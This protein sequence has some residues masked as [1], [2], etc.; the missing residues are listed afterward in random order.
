MTDD[1]FRDL[2]R[3]AIDDYYGEEVVDGSA[4]DRLLHGAALRAGPVRRPGGLQAPGRGPG[5]ARPPGGARQ[6]PVLPGHAAEPVRRPD[7]AARRGRPR[8]A[9]RVRRRA[10]SGRH[11]GLDAGRHREAVRPRPGRRRANWTASIGQVFDERQVYRI[12][13]YLGKE[14]VQNILVFRF[15]NA[16]FEPLWNRR[17]VDHV[18]ITVAETSASSTAAGYYEQAGALRDMIQN[19][20]LQ[21][22][23]LVAMEPPAAFDADAVRD[24]KVKVLR[25]VRPITCPVGDGTGRCAGSTCRAGS[26]SRR[27]RPTAPRSGSRRTRN[28]ETFA[29]LQA[30]RRQLAL[31]GRAVL[32]AHRQA[33]GRVASPRSPSTSS[34][35]RS[36]SSASPGGW[37]P[38]A[39]RPRPPRAAG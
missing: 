9:R 12:D 39:Q 27:R 8:P 36:R 23:S 29:A 22:L 2:M 24:E 20:L 6:P 18:Q 38:A 7:R 30:L 16:I 35:R 4:C 33:P 17:Y 19:H 25:A 28:T 34:G 15:A 31:A 3:T 10:Q 32:P 21:L 5:R 26:A 13:H 1:Q 11:P 37:R 14:T